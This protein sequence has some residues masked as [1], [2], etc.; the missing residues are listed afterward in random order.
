MMGN[1]LALL[2]LFAIAVPVIIHLL[3]QHRARVLRF[4]TLRFLAASRLVPTRRRRLSDIPLLLVRVGIVAAAA[5]ALSQPYFAW[6]GRRPMSRE[7]AG[8]RAIIVDTS[9]SMLRRVSSTES[10][11]DSA[12]R[13]AA[14]QRAD[15]ITATIET[16]DPGKA[17]SSAVAWLATRAG[18]RELLIVSDFQTTAIDSAAIAAVPADI[19]ISLVAIPARGAT[20][21]IEQRAVKP[22]LLAGEGGQ[23]LAEAALRAGAPAVDAPATRVGIV[24]PDYP[25]GG[26]LARRAGPIA[27]W[28]GPVVAALQVDRTLVAAARLAIPTPAPTGAATVVATSDRGL[29]VVLAGSDGNRLLLF[30]LDE[31]GGLSSAALGRAVLTTINTRVPGRELDTTSIAATTLARWQRPAAPGQ[32]GSSD[33]S[34]GRFFWMLALLLLGL[35]SLMRSRKRPATDVTPAVANVEERAA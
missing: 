32:R 30:L 28:M 14:A 27:G 29:P 16:D 18:A 9:A 31:P 4:P 7:S 26:E 20:P 2:G 35:E 17:V 23:P 19:G 8:S 11:L 12:R 5:V 1:P 13:S 33:P 34:D 25:D 22:L 3:G 24:F 21:V 10:A 6:T 15:W